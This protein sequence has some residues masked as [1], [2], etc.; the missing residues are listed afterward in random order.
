M[1]SCPANNAPPKIQF[2]PIKLRLTKRTPG[3]DFYLR[4][5]GDQATYHA[6]RPSQQ[7]EIFYQMIVGDE[8]SMVVLKPAQQ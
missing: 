2:H 1:S 5:I 7:F 8:R 4:M 6:R 3:G